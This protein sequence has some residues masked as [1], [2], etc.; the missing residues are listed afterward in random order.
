MKN[1][2]IKL[3]YSVLALFFLSSCEKELPTYYNFQGYEFASREPD[4][5]SWTPVL[6]GSGDEIII[7]APEPATSASYLQEIEDLKVE[8]AQMSQ[9]DES[10]VAYWT[11]NPIIRWN[12]IALELIAKY[13]L[14]PGPNDD[15]TY[16]LPSPSNPSGPP[17]FPFAHPPY[18]VRALAYLSVAQFDGLISAWHH[19]FNYNRSAPF[20][21]DES[22]QP[23]YSD[24]IE[25]SYP[26]DGAVVATVSR[27]ILTKMFPLEAEYLAK[28]EAEHL[29]SLLLSGANVQSDI[30]AGQLIGD[31]IS[32]IALERAENDGMKNAQ[33]PKSVS[34][35]LAAAAQDR[36]GWQ[37]INVEI[38][39]RPVG[40]TPL[41]SQVQ[42]WSVDNVEQTRPIP[43]PAVGSPE[44][45]EDV[46]ILKDYANNVTE[47]RRR[48]ANFWQDGLGTYTPPGHWN[49]FAKEFI[50]KYRLNPLR[51]ARTFAYLNMAMMDG[52]ISCWDAKYYF[53]YPRPV[54]TIQG[55]K[56]IA[57]TPNFPAY[58]S[59]HSV[60]SAAGAEILA[61]IFP[62]EA[63]LVR[64]WAQEAAISRVYG[65]IH[66][67]FDA[68][69]GTDQGI[70]VAQYTLTTARNDGAD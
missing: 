59:G 63:S 43:P 16:T 67:T 45:Q 2:T 8:M 34:D 49:E 29:R 15:G 19:K 36:F 41:Y 18:A 46:A 70:D 57:G 9:A 68:T 14:I 27:Q 66:W 53:H 39:Q 50:V 23:A 12:E 26:S 61:Y 51:S 55:F 28:K 5:G 4:G 60:F 30:D 20:I 21:Q 65:G 40:L 7:P 56:T 13:N 44:Y 42:M 10:A 37:W 58:T 54:Q 17:A 11:Q 47:E 52:G 1:N 62:S 31:A 38:P 35:S 33:A 32:S 64:G 22:I 25:L 3:I 6:I 48:I 24:N 69:V